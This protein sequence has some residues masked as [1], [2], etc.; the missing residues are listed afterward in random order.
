MIQDLHIGHRALALGLIDGPALTRALFAAAGKKGAK[1]SEVLLQLDTLTQEQLD[2]VRHDLQQKPQSVPLQ[3][4]EPDP[5]LGSVIL[6][7]RCDARLEYQPYMTT[8]AGR[9]PRDPQPVSLLLVEKDALRNGLWIDGFETLRSSRNVES[10]NLLPVLAVDTCD[11]GFGVVYRYFPGAIT[12]QGLLDKIQ[13]LKL[14]EAL[15]IT[16]EVAQGLEDL[17]KAGLRHRDLNLSNVLLTRDGKVYLRNQGLVFEP[18]G[19][20]AFG[21]GPR[22]VYGTPYTIAPECLK[23]EP[24][25]PASDVYALGVISYRMATGVYPFEGDS[26]ATLG[27]QHLESTALRPHEY[28]KALPESVSDLY[29]WLLSKTPKERPDTTK[30]VAVLGTLEKNIHRTGQTQKLQ[31][32]KPE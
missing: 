17:H 6:D 5:F 18:E 13:R 20:T 16:R 29:K 10:K 24:P 14:S 31:A 32:F 23:G 27:K 9:L 21:A 22:Q 7:V 19:A 12:L 15:R 2:Q 28:L 4:P 30:L 8:Y 1:L 26:L 11:H 3:A 25:H